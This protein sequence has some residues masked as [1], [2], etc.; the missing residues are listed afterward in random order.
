MSPSAEDPP[1]RP[2][3]PST[4]GARPASMDPATPNPRRTTVD[5]AMHRHALWIAKA[6][7]RT[8]LAPLHAEDVARLSQ[9]CEVRRAQAGEV[10]L[11]AG[12][13]VTAIIVVRDGEIHLA[14][15]PRVGGRQPIQRIRAGGVVGDIP[16][17]CELPIPFDAL[18]GC[19]ATV[20]VLPRDELVGLLQQ[21]P[22]LSLRWMMSLAKRFEQTQRRMVTLL[23][24]D[25]DAQIASV[26][27]DEREHDAANGWVVRLSHATLAGMLGARRQSVSRALAR[28]RKAGVVSGGYRLIKL[29]DLPELATL[30]GEALPD[31]SAWP[32]D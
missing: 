17:L 31:P 30:A 15:R 11:K 29:H 3:R 25:L 9:I 2:V 4:N 10:L 32:T 1:A 22:T 20:L 27:L 26:L 28:F 18:A 23:T 5:Q 7:A 13:P 14:A 12:E 8:D 24:G 19:D 6:M 21:S 16:M